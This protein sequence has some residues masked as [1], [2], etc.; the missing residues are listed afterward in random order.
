MISKDRIIK[1]VRSQS[2]SVGKRISSN[3]KISRRD[4]GELEEGE[5]YSS[6]ESEYE[7]IQVDG[8]QDGDNGHKFPLFL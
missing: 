2:I 7:S 5:A 4:E 3:I 8:D 6:K 1:P